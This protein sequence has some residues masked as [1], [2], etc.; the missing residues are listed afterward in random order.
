MAMAADWEDTDMWQKVK[1]S[2]L[3]VATAKYA[4]R[5]AG[6]TS[7]GWFWSVEAFS[8]MTQR[9]NTSVDALPRRGC[10]CLHT[11]MHVG[12]HFLCIGEWNARALAC[13]NHSAHSMNKPTHDCVLH[14]NQTFSLAHFKKKKRF[15]LMTQQRSQRE[16]KQNR[17]LVSDEECHGW[18]G[19][20]NDCGPHLWTLVFGT[21]V[22]ARMVNA[23]KTPSDHIE[24]V[25]WLC[26]YCG[27]GFTL[28]GTTAGG[29]GGDLDMMCL[30]L[31][32]FVLKKKRS[33]ILYFG[34]RYRTWL[35]F[36][37]WMSSF[38][39]TFHMTRIYRQYI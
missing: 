18:R 17:W 23:C 29:G 3:R 37:G 24:Q 1:S 33:N 16:H 30:S 6:P 2:C 27:A 32:D 25:S 35:K 31:F 21:I 4:T 9:A 38:S 22:N 15:R 8:I 7:F 36:F 11:A 5:S 13:R 14:N 34:F 20:G 39:L 19:H 26:A 28:W 10:S 12:V